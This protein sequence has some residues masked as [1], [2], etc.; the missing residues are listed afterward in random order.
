MKN[1]YLITISLFAALIVANAAFAV[2]V[3]PENGWW[4]NPSRSGTGFNIETQNNVMFVATF[5]YDEAGQPIWY[6]GSGQLD[7]NGTVTMGLFHSEGGPCIGCPYQAPTTTDAGIP[8]T[9]KF[10]SRGEG[11]V[12]WQGTQE[13]IQRFNFN[14]GDGAQLLLGDWVLISSAPDASNSYEEYKITF[15]TA[16]AKGDVLGSMTDAHYRTAQAGMSDK[17][18]EFAKEFKYWITVTLGSTGSASPIKM[19]VFNFKGFKR[20]EGLMRTI[21]QFKQFPTKEIYGDSVRFE[22]YRID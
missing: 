15:N 1:K 10:T 12:S 11:T 20:I 5:V 22:G 8:I 18:K 14:Q 17:A 9:L 4:V 21:Y 7:T 13:P 3:T 6:S 19:F 16:T 2:T